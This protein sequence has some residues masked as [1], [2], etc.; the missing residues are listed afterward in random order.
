MLRFCLYVST[1]RLARGSAME[2]V[3]HLVAG[4]RASNR[5]LSV[6]GTLIFSGT[7]FAQ[8]LEGPEEKLSLLFQRICR[9]PRHG[10]IRVLLDSRRER[11]EFPRRSLQFSGP[12][13][14]VDRHIGQFFDEDLQGQQRKLAVGQLL[15]M[16]RGTT[17]AIADGRRLPPRSNCSGSEVDQFLLE[18]PA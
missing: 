10:Q 15:Q 17:Q 7:Y 5:R 4:A 13:M 11:R 1:C 16:M 14:F 18:S 6:S 9:D 3:Y 2:E 12:S 8:Y